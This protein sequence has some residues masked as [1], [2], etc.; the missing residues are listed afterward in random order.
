MAEF[1]LASLRQRQALKKIFAYAR[2]YLP[3]RSIRTLGP[4]KVYGKVILRNPNGKVTIGRRSTL[5]P[6]VV[7]DFDAASPGTTPRIEIGERT[8][9]GDR[10]EIHCGR[11]VRIGNHVAISWDCVIMESD[12]HAAGGS[13]VIPRPI[14]IEDEAWIGCRVI[15]LKGVT[16]GR[17]AIIGAGS[18]VTKD[19]PPYTL[20][21]GNPAKVIKTVEPWTGKGKD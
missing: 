4:V 15:I 8:A 2:G 11:N 14:V 20:V 12:Y 3:R 21:A 17:G 9:L 16:V 13:D 7:F 1:G 10:T 19:V 18:V 6:N 5:W